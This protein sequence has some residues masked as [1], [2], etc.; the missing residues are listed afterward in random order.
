MPR[1][2]F[3]IKK[4][5][6]ARKKPSFKRRARPQKK[7]PLRGSALRKKPAKV[8]KKK[9]AKAKKK[10]VRKAVRP[11]KAEPIKKLWSEIF[12]YSAPV[13]I[14][15]PE[16]KPLEAEAKPVPAAVASEDRI[17]TAPVTPFIPKKHLAG[18]AA[19]APEKPTPVVFLKNKP[20]SAHLV[21][22][23]SVG[24]RKKYKKQAAPKAGSASVLRTISIRKTKTV[25]HQ[26]TPIAF[27]E[28][29]G[30]AF[31]H[32]ILTLGKII[33]SPF[34]FGFRLAEKLDFDVKKEIAP[35]PVQTATIATI[36]EP[37]E[38]EDEKT[39][40]NFEF[41]KETEPEIPR[42]RPFNLR[43]AVLS[44]ATVSLAV[45]LPL[46]GMNVYR[47]L[48]A[49]KTQAE[50]AGAKGIALVEDVQDGVFP[51]PAAIDS[52]RAAFSD[53]AASLDRIGAVPDALLSLVPVL[54]EKYDSGKELVLAGQDL[55]NAIAP[56]KD[57]SAALAEKSDDVTQKI[58]D[59]ERAASVAEPLLASASS[60]LAKVKN[61]P[62]QISE[63]SF[64][65]KVALLQSADRSLRS[66]LDLAPSLYE[67]L[68]RDSAKRY[69][70]IFQNNAELRPTGGFM[71]SFAL[72]DVDRGR[73]TKI[74]V[75]AGGPYD[76]QGSLKASVL[77]PDPLRL[78]NARWQFQDANWY[79]D[80]PAS[81]KK[82]AWF[83]GKAGGPS[84]DGVIALNAPVLAKLIDATGPINMPGYDKLVTADTV[85]KT[86]QEIV[87]SDAARESGQPK[88]FIAD[89]L[90]KVLDK[91]TTAQG[92]TMLRAV[93]IFA[94]SLANKDVQVYLSDP[95]EQ[96]K[97][98][99]FGWTGA[100]KPLAPATDSF[101]LV[102]ANIAGQKTDAVI[103]TDIKHKTAIADDGTITDTVTVTLDHAGQKGEPF[104]GVR[105][106]EYVR[107]YVPEG[108]V[109]LRSG[110]DI[111]PPDAKLFDLPPA[112]AAPDASLSEITGPVVHDQNTGVAVNN[113]FGRTV[114]GAWTQTDPGNSS[115][116]TFVYTLPWKATP[117][118]TA[119]PPAEKLMNAS[120]PGATYRHELV[121]TPQSGAGE[122]TVS[123]SLSLP[124][125][126][127]PLFAAPAG[128]ASSNGFET[129]FNLDSE[130]RLTLSAAVPN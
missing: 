111:R 5:K 102:R 75:P 23:R 51:D 88:Q 77:A 70:V 72:V 66:F 94:E 35:A 2:K 79:P 96:E 107:A 4:R 116:L 28:F 93:S 43:R 56:L 6:P 48:D 129:S 84:V 68:G 119:A 82:I 109:L 58:A 21:D 113:E 54:G 76:L 73:I 42:G 10:A 69:L 37:S 38:P 114:F 22:L 95:R 67:I 24:V 127:Y 86:T 34:V 92:D 60:E 29:V 120:L 65:Q 83:Y 13:K 26:T 74:E 9:I 128:I 63:E 41:E 115:S 14:D 80:F 15:E 46:E 105:N 7:S 17:F 118:P 81:A 100:I 31:V 98:S 89:L 57:L 25:W 126:W 61:P 19:P 123:A 8:F 27:I 1:A 71:G 101:E 97:I 99:A 39:E 122:T 85:L 40:E 49:A 47:S 20:V 78:V 18:K 36:E 91:I 121:F 50:S 110:G 11:A 16:A 12:S 62:P 130:H 53:A 55:T 117:V 59:L 108:S 64:A 124:L 87:E 52:A 44:F 104:T 3:K 30:A 32:G 90:P 125:S 33:V 103:R 112:G 45:V 106:V